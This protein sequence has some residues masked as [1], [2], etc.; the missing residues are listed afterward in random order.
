MV[1]PNIEAVFKTYA[2]KLNT[3]VEAKSGE[4]LDRLDSFLSQTQGAQDQSSV[5]EEGETRERL[6]LEM[7]KN[8]ICASL[9]SE[10]TLLVDLSLPMEND[11]IT[12]LA[13]KELMT[14]SRI[15]MIS[16]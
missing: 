10:G 2:D 3:I 13:V 16:T 4:A 5:V 8:D 6:F 7:R 11:N 14:E 15:E 12:P 9:T 1:K